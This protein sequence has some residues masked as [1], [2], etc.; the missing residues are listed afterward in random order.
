MTPS[1]TGAPRTASSPIDAAGTLPGRAARSTAR[2]E[3]KTIL[4]ADRETFA[5]CLTEKMLTYALGR[6]LE[7]YDRPAVNLICRRLAA[8]DYRFSSLVL[9]IVKSMPFQMRRGE[10]PG[11]GHSNDRFHRRKAMITGKHLRGARFCAAWAR[12][13]RCPCWMR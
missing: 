6:G 11:R 10:A 2:R 13:S 4:T 7:R 5:Q 1:A 8:N 3:L 9:G 12:R